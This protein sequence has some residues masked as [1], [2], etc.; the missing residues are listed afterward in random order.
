MQLEP[1]ILWYLLDWRVFMASLV[2]TILCFL[3]GIVAAL[4]IFFNGRDVMQKL[5]YPDRGA[6]ALAF[7]LI[8]VGVI[9]ASGCV[10]YYLMKG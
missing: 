8:W 2:L 4:W 6:K 1:S 3:F 10:I 5:R 7:A 9:L